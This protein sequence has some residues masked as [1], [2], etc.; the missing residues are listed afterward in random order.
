MNQILNN[1]TED[2]INKLVA[3][4]GF[5]FESN[6]IEE[7]IKAVEE[8][9]QEATEVLNIN[10]LL[11]EAQ[12]FNLRK[13]KN[14]IEAILFLSEKPRAIESIAKEA[15]IDLELATRAMS[16]LVQEYEDRDGG[17]TIDCSDGYCM[18]ISDEFEDLT[19]NILPIELRSAV[20]RTLSTIALKEPILQSDLVKIRGGGVYEHVK[21]LID[22]GLVKRTK[23]GHSNIVHTSKFFTENFKLSQNGIE[24]QKVLKK[25]I[26]SDVEFIR[27]KAAEEVGEISEEL[28]ESNNNA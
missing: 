8:V 16:Q 12:S 20:L 4:S 27:P 18:Q 19:E 21:E 14:R 11:E 5:D 24:L 7:E 28:E 9:I 1:S 15:N 6:N 17:I 23:D 22:M 13:I 3:S 2:N 26:P 25:A 10:S